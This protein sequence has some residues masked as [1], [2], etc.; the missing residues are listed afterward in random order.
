MR[1][2]I[3]VA[4]LAVPIVIALLWSRGSR[5]VPSVLFVAWLLGVGLVV[6]D[7][8]GYLE[9]QVRAEVA[10]GRTEL[11]SHAQS[12][13]P[14]LLL[15]DSGGYL[16]VSRGPA[17]ASGREDYLLL[18]TSDSLLLVDRRGRSVEKSLRVFETAVDYEAVVYDVT[19]GTRS[20]GFLI[21]VVPAR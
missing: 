14:D 11:R 4:A 21:E 16:E 5:L 3:T 6:L 17:E 2:L 13:D 8:P 19:N 7:I 9:A 20:E 1:L 12:I 15:D 18:R 10:L